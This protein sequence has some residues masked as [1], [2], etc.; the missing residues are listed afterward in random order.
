MVDQSVGRA[1]RLKRFDFVD[2]PWGT[3]PTP[4]VL[5]GFSEF[6]KANTESK[7]KADAEYLERYKAYDIKASDLERIRNSAYFYE[8]ELTK[9]SIRRFAKKVCLKKVKRRFAAMA[10]WSLKGL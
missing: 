8:T 5:K 3:R 4:E 10:R 9:A 1:T 7:A 2:L 6:I